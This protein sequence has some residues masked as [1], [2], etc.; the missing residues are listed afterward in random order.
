MCVPKGG[1][2]TLV[3]HPLLYDEDVDAHI[4]QTGSAGVPGGVED[5]LLVILQAHFGPCDIPMTP[6]HGAGRHI[7]TQQL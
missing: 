2:D 3:A 6:D 1:I 4:D 7:P 5:E